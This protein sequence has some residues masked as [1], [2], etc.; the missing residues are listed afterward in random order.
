MFTPM[1]AEIQKAV[2]A[3][4]LTQ[5]A[6]E[7]LKRLPEGAFCFHKSWGFGKIASV[8]FL[9]NQ[10]TI[11]FKGKKAHPMQLQ[12]AAESLQPM[13]E[14]HILVQKA[15][16]LAALKKMAK[17]QPLELVRMVLKSYHGKATAEQIAQALAPEVMNEAEFKRWWEGA[18]KV[19][20]ADEYFALPAKKTDPVTL[21]TSAVSR[22]EELLAAFANAR[23]L[24]EQLVIV[25]QIGKSLG[26][27]SDPATQLQPVVAAIEATAR[28]GQKLHTAQAFELLFARD[29]ICENVPALQRGES[30]LTL[31]QLLKEE[32]GRLAASLANVASGK[33]QRV[34]A[35][36]PEAY[37]EVWVRKALTLML[38]VNVRLVGEIAR[39]LQDQKKHEDLR[40]ALDRWIS[41]HSITTEVLHWLCKE[42]EG[43]F[44]DLI[45]PQVF[46][47]IL[48]ALERDQFSDI[49]RGAKL[50]VILMEDRELLPQLLV[51][52]EP[53]IVRDAMRKLLAT[54][55]FDELNKRSLL[56]RIIKVHP[57]MQS[58]LTGESGERQESLIVSW[59]TLEKR[60]NELDEL[61]NKKIPENVKEI[62]VARSYGDLRENFEYKAAKE[63]Q[64][65][66]QRRKA[67]TERDLGRARGTNFENPD[68]NKV[69][70]GTVVTVR[71]VNSNELDSY[72]ILGA[73]DSEPE[74]Q[75]ISYLSAVGQALLEKK[76]GEQVE[77][78]T[79][80]SATRR[81]EIVEIKA[82]ELPVPA[83]ASA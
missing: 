43:D 14:E 7:T 5:P 37:G 70:I 56:G 34:F 62:S 27:F 68:A 54:T 21:R 4:K 42:R 29:E 45:T 40:H 78:P 73:W 12:Y 66:L 18:K 36:F 67:E 58:M 83:E 60:K 71:E 81:V 35:A 44:A 46:S 75:I 82:Y 47:A 26:S 69:S 28:K 13:T 63:M 9:L 53:E 57:E 33:L 31:A 17:E 55:V 72:T 74:Q 11:D 6:A 3:G 38:R 10:V 61:V 39:L 22:A 15:T 23:V 20:K 80:T 79:E 48:T 30:T 51:D 49:K 50:H 1:E 52:A 24:K 64:R 25:E 2:A 41:E 8:N 32:E 65:V 76:P 19:L 77:L 59:S 16:N